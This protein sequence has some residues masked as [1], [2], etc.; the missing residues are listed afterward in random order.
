MKRTPLK[1][2]SKKR[3]KE[4]TTYTL[5]R[6]VFLIERPYCEIFEHGCTRK[7]TDVHHMNHRE[8]KKLNM[9]EWWLPAC[10]TCHDWVRD[11]PK[12]ARDKGFLK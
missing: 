6:R 11:H 9:R 3:A 7:S 1:R 4:N 8:G 10:R 2:V 12:L 5:L